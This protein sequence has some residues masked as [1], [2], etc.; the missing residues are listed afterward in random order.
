MKSR[1]VVVLGTRGIPDIQGGVETHCEKLYPHLV[2]KGYRVTLLGRSNTM[3]NQPYEYK[4]VKVLPLWAPKTAGLEAALHTLLGILKARLMG[5][6]IV[7]LHAIGPALW[8]PL[9]R[10]L[11]LNVVVTHHGPDYDRQKWGPTA[12]FILR[13]G[14]KMGAR[15]AHRLV[16]ISETI[17]NS[18]EAKYHRYDTDLIF[19]GVEIPPPDTPETVNETLRQYGL[20]DRKYLLTVGRLVPEKGFH[21]LIEA[22][23]GRDDIIVVIAGDSFPPTVYSETLRKRASELDVVMT[24][25]VKGPPLRHLFRGAT[26]FVL[27]SYHE[28]LPIALLEAMSFGKDVLVSDIAANRDVQLPQQHYFQ[29]GDIADLHRKALARLAATQTNDFVAIV[30]T[31]YDWGT[32]AEQTHQLY[33]S[34]LVGTVSRRPVAPKPRRPKRSRHS[35][36]EMAEAFMASFGVPDSFEEGHHPY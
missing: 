14:E 7:H 1:H 8:A 11:L 20:K 28:G 34:L 5:A 6:D 21:D 22:M 10:F 19:N 35:S 12:K 16:V 24:G 25:F 27:P 33:Q 3:G 23:G 29:T 31:R 18:L 36:T 9:A 32:I 15:Y 17:R 4:G 26:L 2:Q 13:Q 30:K